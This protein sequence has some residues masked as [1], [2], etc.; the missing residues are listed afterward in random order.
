MTTGGVP[1]YLDAIRK[2]ESVYQY[3]DRI[4]FKKDGILQGE[5]EELFQSLFDGSSNHYNVVAT[6]ADKKKGLTRNEIVK[7]SNL[8]SGGTLTKVLD[9]LIESGFVQQAVPYQKNKTKALYKLIDSFV[10]FYHKF[11]KDAK[12]S[13]MPHWLNMVNKQSWISWSGL[14]FERLCH[15]HKDQIRKSLRLEA[16]QS[17]ISSWSNDEAQVDMLIDRADRI[18]NLCEIKFYNDEYTI[19]KSY[20]ARLRKKKAQLANLKSSKRKSIFITMITAFGVKDNQ[21]YKELVQSQVT[22]SALFKS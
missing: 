14:A 11:M 9:E 18:V 17:E 3:V 13:T 15:Y 20:A 2:G 5:Y 4:C 1:Y 8:S 12:V 7:Q 16:I 22:L 10:I 6:L 21:Y 19:D